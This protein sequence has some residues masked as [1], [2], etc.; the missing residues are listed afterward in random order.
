MLIRPI[1]PNHFP[2]ALRVIRSN[3]VSGDS[4]LFIGGLTHKQPLAAGLFQ[5]L[6]G[7]TSDREKL[8]CMNL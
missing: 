5:I 1:F 2:P 7:K 8:W 3:Y 6:D 4:W